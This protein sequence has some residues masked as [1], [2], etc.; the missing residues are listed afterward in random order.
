MSCPTLFE[1]S[2]LL[3]DGCYQC[4]NCSALDIVKDQNSHNDWYFNVVMG[5]AITCGLTEEYCWRLFE[6]LYRLQKSQFQPNIQL[7][8]KRY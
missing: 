5:G 4:R 2:L 3:L 8:S 7:E 6:H 1:Q